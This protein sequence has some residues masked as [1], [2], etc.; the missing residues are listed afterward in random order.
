MGHDRSS[1]VYNLCGY[2]IFIKQRLVRNSTERL[3]Y[4]KQG[5]ITLDI[6]L[7]YHTSRDATMQKSAKTKLSDD[8]KLLLKARRMATRTRAAAACKPC[9]AKKSKC[10]DYR[11]CAQCKSSQP[12]LC[13]EKWKFEDQI[14]SGRTWDSLIGNK[15]LHLHHET[16]CG[17]FTYV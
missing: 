10:S 4:D 5:F 6:I 3:Q 12:S 1:S 8:A 7:N 11:P 14:T 2:L 16:D 17:S 13:V 9:R 15:Y